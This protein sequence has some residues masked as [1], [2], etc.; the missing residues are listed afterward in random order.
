MAEKKPEPGKDAYQ[1]PQLKK[2]GR[3]TNI[4]F[5]NSY[6]SHPLKVDVFR[7]GEAANYVLGE[8]PK[9][10]ELLGRSKIGFLSYKIFYKNRVVKCRQF[11]SLKRAEKTAEILELFKSSA[12]DLVPF[13]GRAGLFLI[14]NWVKGKNVRL[15]DFIKQEDLLE[16][17]AQ[18]HD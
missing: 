18:Q 9:K 15:V 10:T 4:R 11:S 16:K 13:E 8:S 12:I 2:E 5:L 3:L 14:F 7:A 17:M 1:K 6:C